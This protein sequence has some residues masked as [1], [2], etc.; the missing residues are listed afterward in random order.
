METNL[1]NN[2]Y[3]K[4]LITIDHFYPVRDPSP[5][6]LNATGVKMFKTS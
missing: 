2:L 1:C 4:S 5:A 6:L 3:A